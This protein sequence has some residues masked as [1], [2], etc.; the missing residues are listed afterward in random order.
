MQDLPSWFD[1]LY[2]P[3]QIISSFI[4]VNIFLYV[5]AL[6]KNTTSKGK[7]E[8]MEN[9]ST[10]KMSIQTVIIKI[11]DREF[12]INLNCTY[13]QIIAMFG[14]PE[15]ESVQRDGSNP[16]IIKYMGL[17]F[18]FHKGALSLIYKDDEFGNVI[19]AIPKII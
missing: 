17:E 18:H 16:A 6:F 14:R 5:C 9:I 12:D 10:I 2:I 13:D 19:T 7:A 15:D 1:Y 3:I 11:G 8:N 4:Q